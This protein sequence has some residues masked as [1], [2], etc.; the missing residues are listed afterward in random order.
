MICDKCGREIK[1]DET[2]ITFVDPKSEWWIDILSG[3]VMCT[4][5]AE[6]VRTEKTDGT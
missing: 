3:V 2:V 1:P 6:K 5:C 4:E